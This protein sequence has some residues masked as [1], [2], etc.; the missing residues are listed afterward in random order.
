[1][2]AD[3]EMDSSLNVFTVV[4]IYKKMFGMF[5]DHLKNIVNNCFS[6]LMGTFIKTLFY[7]IANFK[8]ANNEITVN[9]AILFS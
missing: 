5:R 1:M 6:N 2:F 4:R 3:D 9:V 8:L 7:N